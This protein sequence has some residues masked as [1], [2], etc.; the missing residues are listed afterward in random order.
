[1]DYLFIIHDYT[2]KRAWKGMRNARMLVNFMVTR[3]E[4]GG[5]TRNALFWK[6]QIKE[7]PFSLFVFS[8]SLLSPLDLNC[9]FGQQLL[10]KSSQH[11]IFVGVSCRFY[12]NCATNIHLYL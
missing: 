6:E 7:F 10:M 12:Y 3:V 9:S 1:M 8:F 4:P 5:G 2:S 11:Y